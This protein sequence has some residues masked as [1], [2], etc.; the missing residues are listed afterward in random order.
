M[1]KTLRWS[2]V[3]TAI[4]LAPGIAAAANSAA[5]P[6]RKP[7]IVFILADDESEQPS[8]EY[9]ST[10]Q[11]RVFSMIRLPS[12]S[13]D[14]LPIVGEFGG[15]TT[16]CYSLRPAKAGVETAIVRWPTA[17]LVPIYN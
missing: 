8:L 6:A 13:G 10:R 15:L 5:A 1:N 3:W 11:M 9:V 7:N 16:L 17:S 12:N 2:L 14:L 4:A